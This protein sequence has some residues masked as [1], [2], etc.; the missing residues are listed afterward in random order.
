VLKRRNGKEGKV[1][2]FVVRSVGEK[3]E[4]GEK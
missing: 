3:R 2:N 1:W 4:N